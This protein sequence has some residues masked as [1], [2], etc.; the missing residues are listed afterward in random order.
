PETLRSLLIANLTRENIGEAYFALSPGGRSVAL[1]R[2]LEG[3]DVDADRVF[4]EL[5]SL[6][7]ATRVWRQRLA[8]GMEVS[9]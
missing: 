1:C 9:Q 5:E 3:D 2:A 8:Q 7:L 4:S 6:V